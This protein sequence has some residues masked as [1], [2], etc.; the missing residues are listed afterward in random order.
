MSLRKIIDWQIAAADGQLFGTIASPFYQYYDIAG[1]WTW[2][3]DVDIGKDEVLRNVPVAT[4]SREIIYAQ[5]GMPVALNQMG[6]NKYAITGLSKKVQS[7]THIIYVSFDDAF[8]RIVNTVTKGFIYRPVT[9]GELGTLLHG[10][11]YGSLPYGARG[12]FDM[13]G[14][15][16]ELLRSY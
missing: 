9:Y 14:N 6:P 12:K 8:G 3:C 2:A 13:Q 7:T 4:S 16:V 5:E 15:L 10:F 1:Q 11:G